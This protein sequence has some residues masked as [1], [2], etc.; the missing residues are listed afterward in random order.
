MSYERF[1]SDKTT[2]RLFTSVLHLLKKHMH[3]TQPYILG[4]HGV[5]EC[6]AHSRVFREVPCT[7]SLIKSSS[8]S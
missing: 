4:E 5:N 3:N 2:G 6:K 7:L 8:F 1:I